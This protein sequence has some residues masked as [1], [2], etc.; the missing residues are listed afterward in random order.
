[1]RVGS[2][3]EG[4]RAERRRGTDNHPGL[5]EGAVVPPAEGVGRRSPHLVEGARKKEAAVGTGVGTAGLLEGKGTPLLP[6]HPFEWAEEVSWEWA[7]AVVCIRLWAAAVL[8]EGVRR[9][10]SLQQVPQPPK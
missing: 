1:M 9:L 6:L 3:R 5:G 7:A 10:P 4:T 2:R 8:A